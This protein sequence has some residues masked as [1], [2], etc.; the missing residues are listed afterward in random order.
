MKY[1][2]HHRLRVRS[3]GFDEAIGAVPGSARLAAKMAGRRER[4]VSPVELDAIIRAYETL[5][6]AIARRSSTGAAQTTS[7]GPSS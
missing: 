5:A 6:E 7:P 1:R 2:I 4:A 3:C